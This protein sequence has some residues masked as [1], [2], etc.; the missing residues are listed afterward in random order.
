MRFICRDSRLVEPGCVYVA[1]RGQAHDGHDFLPQV[2]R[3]G[4]VGVVVESESKIPADYPGAV[5]VVRDCR[6]ALDQ[7]ASRYYN[8]P[9]ASMYCVGVTGTNGKT[10]LA[11]LVESILNEY[12]WS[13]GVMGTVDHHIGTHVW[14][15]QLTT[16]DALDLQKRL[17]EFKSLGA[18]AVAFEVS[19]HAL[20]QFRADAIPFDAVVFTNLTRDHLD[21]HGD[22]DSY[23]SAKQ[24]LFDEILWGSEKRDLYAIINR[25]DPYGRKLRIADK[26]TRWTYGEREA[27]FCF[28]IMDQGFSG[29]RYEIRHPR[30]VTE[31]SS[32]LI[33]RH[34]VYNCTAAFAVGLAAG[35]SSET[36]ATALSRFHGVPGRMER[37]ENQKGIHVF[38]DYAH[39]DDALKSV[40]ASLNE[41]R[42]LSGST[43]R[44]ISVFGCGGD[45]DKGKRPLM[46][47]AAVEGSDLVFV[48]S[49]NPRTED[50]EEIIQDIFSGI[51]EGDRDH[52]VFSEVDRKQAISRALRSANSGDV[53]LI[54]GKGH[55]GYQ[56]VGT[57]KLSFCDVNV[58][59]DLLQ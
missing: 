55:E 5:A 15:S 43:A 44:I 31:I 46:A 12:G 51:E 18:K 54:A 39:T 3:A 25:D 11:Y 10:S 8:N 7:L 28:Q 40:L 21:Y 22:L 33:G 34:N 47:K 1:V 17:V 52:K 35:V 32:P 27:D 29:C 41:I 58:V 16:P 24:R 50:P 56:I 26:A 42:R 2:C 48:T 20:S 45:R 38:V 37:V 36:C 14:E 53:V 30:G 19:S 9:A 23:F 59:K 6:K 49:D 4:A 57:E 13:T